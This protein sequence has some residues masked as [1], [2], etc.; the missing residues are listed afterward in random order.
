MINARYMQRRREK[1]AAMRRAYRLDQI[2]RERS[3]LLAVEATVLEQTPRH[4]TRWPP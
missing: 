4:S 1:L 3:S 2:N